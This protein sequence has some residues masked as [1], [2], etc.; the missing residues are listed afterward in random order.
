M[1]KLRKLLREADKKNGLP[2]G[3]MEAIVQQ[4][5]G[6]NAAYLKDP[7]KYHYD[8][9]NS[10]TRRTKNGTASS[11]FGLFG[12]L[13]STANKPGYGVAPLK[14]KSLAEQV[15]FA[16]EYLGARVKASGSLEKGL[17]GYGEGAKYARQVTSRIPQDPGFN[18]QKV[19]SV[20]DLPDDQMQQYKNP[21]DI[22]L[23][24]MFIAGNSPFR[25]EGTRADP[26]ALYGSPDGQPMSSIAPVEPGTVNA[27][28]ADANAQMSIR[29]DMSIP[30][31]LVQV[32]AAEQAQLAQ[33][34]AIQARSIENPWKAFQMLQGKN[35]GS[36]MNYGVKANAPD[37][38]FSKFGRFGERKA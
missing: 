20:L 10:G 14:D 15:R 34:G 28:L 25:L 27:M 9:D 22:N 2:A 30:P 3:T 26:D 4:E 16:S 13:D 36:G 21:S 31:E 37:V 23:S 19:G 12:I 5:T 38:D 33:L 17:A 6:G 35:L 29:P 18:G 24:D 1:E 32:A 11:A 7:A 8:P